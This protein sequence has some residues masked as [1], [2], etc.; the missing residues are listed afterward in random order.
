MRARL[1]SLLAMVLL[2]PLV[3]LA[4]CSVDPPGGELQAATL[5]SEGSPD[6]S[7]A[8]SLQLDGNENEAAAEAL[9]SFLDEHGFEV[10]LQEG[11]LVG[12]RHDDSMF[13]LSPKVS[14]EGIDRIVVAKIFGVEDRYR[15]S[16]EVER[17][18]LK[19]ND[20]YNIGTFTL[21]DDGDLM[22]QSHVT[23]VDR[24]ELAEI[25]AF[26]EFVDRSLMM[27]VLGN[28]RTLLYLE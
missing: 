22:Y 6:T 13:I 12:V 4:A 8:K 18:I 27:A 26:L 11:Q 1:H 25:E 28:P 21:D 7:G 10:L 9:A 14:S 5:P 17:L 19:L 15:H 24:I 23:F 3:A 16:D 20:D 2:V